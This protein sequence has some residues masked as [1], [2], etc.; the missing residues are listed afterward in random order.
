MNFSLAST[1]IDDLLRTK[2]GVHLGAPTTSAPS[3][4]GLISLSSNPSGA[5]IE[6]DGV[7]VGTT[8]AE[9]PVAVGQRD[10]QITKRGFKP[11]D[12]KVEIITGAK[13]TISPEL[14]PNGE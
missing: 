6:I 1:E 14:E 4:T 8:P 12:R 11:F 10:I 13:Q 9:I 7:F 2:F 3:Q 5:D